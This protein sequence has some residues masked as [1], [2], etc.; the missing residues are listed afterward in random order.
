[1]DRLTR[2]AIDERLR[3]LEGISGTV[4][5]CVEELT[6]MRSVLPRSTTAATASTSTSSPPT[7]DR[8]SGADSVAS[9]STGVTGSAVQDGLSQPESVVSSAPLGSGSNSESDS[10]TLSNDLDPP[11]P[12]PPAPSS[13]GEAESSEQHAP[14]LGSDDDEL[15]ENN[16]TDDSN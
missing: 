11:I 7:A 14:G 8:G 3:V 12:S 9:T 16:V 1:M 4:W 10:N 13:N 15:V 2:E 6:R 5:R